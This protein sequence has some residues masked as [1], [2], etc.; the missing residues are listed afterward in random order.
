MGARGKERRS[1]VSQCVTRSLLYTD[2]FDEDYEDRE[3]DDNDD[4]DDDRRPL[5]SFA[6][7]NAAGSRR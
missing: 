2:A 7:E 3:D 5:R 1:R 6:S 4:D